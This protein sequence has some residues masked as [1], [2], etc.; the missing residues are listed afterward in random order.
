LHL[1][2]VDVERDISVGSWLDVRSVEE[3][4]TCATCEAGT[5]SIILAIEVGHIFKLG[6]RYAEALGATVLDENGKPATMVM[7]SY[8][9]G[10]G[11]SM[12]AVVE[13]HH[14]DKGIVWPVSVA[15]FEVVI[16]VLRP[17]QDAPRDAGEQLY[18]ELRQQGIDVILDDRNERPGVKFSDAEL[19]GIPYR[20]TVGPRGLEHAE[21]E[22]KARDGS[23]DES[24]AVDAIADRLV[25]LVTARR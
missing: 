22:L 15:P 25:K 6:R 24:V 23:C 10:V 20:V 17:D 16:T 18:R 4:E 8:G 9:I 19:V 5:L 14:D 3:G 11:R 7:G 1:R 21:V 12:A 2:G 13:I